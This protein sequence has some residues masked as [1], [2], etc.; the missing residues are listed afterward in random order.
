[1]TFSQFYK[2]LGVTEEEYLKYISISEK[3]NVLILKRSIRERFINNYNPEMITAWNANMDIQLALDPYA[4]ITYIVS[5]VSKDESGMTKFLKQALEN[6]KDADTNT[7]LKA[8]KYAYLTNRQMG[9]SEAVAKLFSS[10]LLKGSNIACIFIASGFPE[11]RS[12]FFKKVYE[13]EEEQDVNDE[14]DE[15]EEL[16]THQHGTVSIAIEGREGKYKQATTVIDRYCERPKYLEMMCLAQFGT[17]YVYAKTIPKKVILDKDGISIDEMSDQ[18]IFNTEIRLPKY[19]EIG[20]NLGFM[21]LRTYPAVLRIHSSKKKEGH[22]QHYSELMLFSH[23][24]NE[25]EEL[26]R[27]DPE[28]CISLYSNE[29]KNEVISNRKKLYPG[30]DVISLMDN[31]DFKLQRPTHIYDTLNGQGEQE[32]ADNNEDGPEDAPEFETF[33]YLG[34]LS[35]ER[36]DGDG[37]KFEDFKFKKANIPTD[38]ERY[39][40]LRRLH[41][42][43]MAAVRRVTKVAKEIKKS[44]NNFQLKPEQAMMIVHGGAGMNFSFGY[45]FCIKL[46]LI[47]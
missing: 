11:N 43:Q 20:E 22:E 5:Y 47:F 25:V 14:E 28:R 21:R 33:G 42:E 29:K 44:R 2:K 23:W 39:E 13:T 10:M 19:I 9:L 45:S 27:N 35:Q 4:V 41:P 18:C 15:A 46:I 34:N 6:H 37:G 8:L 36:E 7:K 32:N 3:G 16:R 40:H 1:M 12:V 24:F 26:A 31:D 17:S 30:E 38:E